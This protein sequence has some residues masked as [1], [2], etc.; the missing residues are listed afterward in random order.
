LFFF[1]IPHVLYWFYCLVMSPIISTFIFL[2]RNFTDTTDV[3]M[4]ETAVSSDP[5]IAFLLDEVLVKDWCKRTIKDIMTEL[6]GICI[7]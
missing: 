6:Q 4:D 1:S 5:I 7:L 3:C 2:T